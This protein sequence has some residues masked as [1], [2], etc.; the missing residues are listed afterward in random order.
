MEYITIM[1]IYFIV[2]PAVMVASE[3]KNFILSKKLFHIKKD[4]YMNVKALILFTLFF[5]NIALSSE[6]KNNLKTICNSL[7]LRKKIGQFFI[8]TVLPKN[9]TN[10]K[11]NIKKGYPSTPK[12]AKELIKNCHIG[13]IIFLGKS[14]IEEQIELTQKFQELTN[15]PLFICQDLEPGRVMKSR[16][17]NTTQY[18]CSQEI[19]Q[20]EDNEIF[21][22]GKSIGKLCNRLGVNVNFAPVVDV[23]TNLNNQVIGDRSFGTTPDIVTHCAILFMQ[24]LQSQNI[25]SC[26]KHF[27]GHGDTIV[28][29]HHDLPII[30]HNQKR[31]ET[32]ELAPF[33]QMIK[34]GIDMIMIGHLLVPALDDSETPTSLSKIIVTDLLRD[35]F[36]F[37]GLIV[38][39]AL[40]MG[41]IVK[42]YDPAQAALLALLAG[43]DLLI[44]CHNI[45]GAIEIILQ[46]IENNI[47]TEQEIDE[48]VMRILRAKQIKDQ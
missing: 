1:S 33:A 17:S 14:D 31:L 47:I 15:I 19:S 23:N 48:H 39:D 35:K 44:C 8:A 11:I 40:E 10:M 34:N 41:A 12:N 21:E 27:P 26:A 46:A 3:Q 28:D 32:I 29:S 6:E 45:P 43:N 30:L 22:I 36:N 18:P 4:P 20:K 37:D 25:I 13:G 38:T 24:G 9:N 5:A 2:P 16:L 7:S 42:H